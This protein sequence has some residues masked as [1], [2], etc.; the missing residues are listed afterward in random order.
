MSLT[1]VADFMSQPCRAL[2]IFLRAAQ[3]PHQ[4]KQIRLSNGEHKTPEFSKLSPFQTVSFVQ[5]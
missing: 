4:V 5:V 2:L 3:V 1:L